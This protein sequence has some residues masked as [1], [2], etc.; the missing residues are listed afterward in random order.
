LYNTAISFNTWVDPGKKEIKDSEQKD[1]PG[2]LYNASLEGI[3]DMKSCLVADG[4]VEVSYKKWRRPGKK[5][6]IS[7]TLGK[8][9]ENILYVFS[10]NCY[11]FE[12]NRAYTPFQVV[13]LLQYGG[14]FKGFAKDLSEKYDVAKPDLKKKEIKKDEPK[15][16]N[17]LLQ[18]LKKTT[19]DLT[20]PIP[21]PPII[22]EINNSNN[23][24]FP[25]WK[26]FMSLG[27]FSAITG[28]SKSKKSMLAALLLA[29]ATDNCVLS[30][31]IKGKFNESKRGVLLFDTEQSDYD[32]YQYG[33]R[34]ENILGG[35]HRPNFGAFALR[36]FSPKQR[37]ELIETALKHFKDNL[38]YVVI[39]GI[40]DLSYTINDE[41]EA[42]TVVNTLMRWTKVYNC[43]ITTIIHQNK[44]DNYATGHLGSFVMKKAE[45]VISVKKVDSHRSNITNDYMRGV[46]AFES[47]GLELS[48][49][50]IPDI[51]NEIDDV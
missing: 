39:D 41:A 45:N 12:P 7:A 14:D 9:D 46:V 34:V 43:H 8:V 31:K 17:D 32:V 20:V 44:N 51:I 25:D 42:N 22:I 6:G 19:I 2:D 40:A 33:R 4:W 35:K 36:E 5:H 37:I 18:I 30:R 23:K 3:E 11:P 28:K 27:N 13:A 1:R 15:K 50:G 16:E 49:D 29:C 48:D 24:D 26:R 38:A 47:F 21:Q 10:S